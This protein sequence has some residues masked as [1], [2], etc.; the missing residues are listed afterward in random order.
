MDPTL[1]DNRYS[2]VV[3]EA[4][5]AMAEEYDVFDYRTG[6]FF[7]NDYRTCN[8]Y[9]EKL[10]PFWKNRVVLDVGC[11]TGLQTIQFA[12][13]ASRVIGVDLSEQL[14][15]KAEF[16]VK[17]LGFKNV[18]LIRGDAIE[19][20]LPDN[21][22]DY[23]SSYGDVIGHIPGYDRAFSE[24]ARVCRP[25][26]IVTIEYDNKWHLGLLYEWKELLQALQKPSKGDIRVWTY[27]YLNVQKNVDLVYKTFA[28]SEIETLLKENNLKLIKVAGIHIL[29]SVIPTQYHTPF[30]NRLP[31]LNLFT[32]LIIA[33]GKI[34]F[35]L[36]ELYPFNRL[37][38]ASILI[39]RKKDPFGIFRGL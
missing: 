23:V 24:M 25:G 31:F 35:V 18:T 30:N 22:V 2:K 4:Y 21:S 10:L 8:H 1:F 6:P 28:F 33:L 15:R 34:D 9:L 32:K 29:S 12:A 14:I 17:S 20:P 11:G 19:L 5:D 36:K 26:G 27:K 3:A 38:F 16:K 37:G 13:Q 7:I 39:A